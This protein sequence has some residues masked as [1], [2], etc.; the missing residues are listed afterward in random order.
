VDVMTGHLDA[1]FQ[2]YR[3]LEPL[4]PVTGCNVFKAVSARGDEVVAIK[5]FP[6]EISRNRPLLE[7][8]RISF[9]SASRLDHPS[10]L[11]IKNFSVHAGRPYVVMP[12]METGSL[13]DRIECGVL[14]A[15]NAEAVIGGIASALE[16]AHSK[17]LVHGNL[18]PSY[19]LFDEDGK[20]QLNGLG[21]TALRRS[22]AYR[23]NTTQDGSFD[24]RAPEVKAGGD[25]TPLADQYSLGLIALQM[26]TNLPIEVA[27]SSL[28]MIKNSDRDQI[29]RTNPF[30]LDL[31]K[32]MMAVLLRALSGDPAKRFPSIQVMYQATRIEARSSPQTEIRGSG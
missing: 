27:A 8:L 2:G 16:L 21:E 6:L 22:R 23:S 11:P 15:M 20:V 32:R 25:I 31:S 29:T 18:M 13:E 17:G 10:I 5:I 24:Y 26:M 12:F 1:N 3:L 7:K 9:Q 30:V 28:E 19:I 14:Q 4:G